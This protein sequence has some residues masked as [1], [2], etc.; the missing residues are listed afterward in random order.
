MRV[1]VLGGTQFLG[2]AIVDEAC[3]RGYDVT[4]FSRGRSG[5]PRP[6]AEPLRGDRTN[7][8]DLSQLTRREWDAVIDTSVLAPAHVLAS[9]QA[10]SGHARHYTYISTI[11]VYA[12]HPA[13]GVTEASPVLD[14]PADA[15]GTVDSLGYGE[16][17][18][19]SERAVGA[20]F[21]HR[22]LIVR[23]GLIVGPHENVRWLTWW[24]GRV[25]RGG[26]ILAPGGPDKRVR[27]TDVRDLAAWVVDNTRR[28]LPA[29]INVPGAGTTFG[30]LLADCLRLASA[31]GGPH[32]ELRWAGDRDL[33]A[34][35]VSPWTELPMW[36][37]DIPEFAG[38]W[39][40]TGDRARRTSMRYRPLSDTVHDTWLWL[41]H[42]VAAGRAPAPGTSPLSLGL[43]PDRE[44][45]VL[46]TL[47]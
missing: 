16:A 13:E 36:A 42:E 46:A 40:M 5:H 34:A 1:L 39:E 22:S 8:G 11:S 30:A 2:R 41:K 18:A 23:P 37:P 15:T 17:K 38:I 10:L 12:N 9:A 14:C 31:D 33:L 44:R 24:L 32:A 20:A 35:G 28:S 26:T 43:D 29:T 6:G 7:P 3:S 27:M 47:G 45:E 25:A 21:P 19:G 4:T